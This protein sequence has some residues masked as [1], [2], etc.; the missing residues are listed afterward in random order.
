MN[1]PAVRKSD[2]RLELYIITIFVLGISV[3][4]TTNTSVQ[5]GNQHFIYLAKSFLEGKLYFS[6]VSSL[7]VEDMSL[8]DGKY[9][10]SLGFIPAILMMPFV[11]IFGNQVQHSVV[12]LPLVLGTVYLLY[13]IS[14]SFLKTK[15]LVLLL[16]FSYVFSTAYIM[17]AIAP[18]SWYFSH[19]VATFFLILSI[20]L[21]ILKNKPFLA[22]LFFSCAFLTRI[23]LLFSLPFFI[24]FPYFFL[25]EKSLSQIIKFIIPVSLGALIFFTYN[26]L[27]F[28]NFFETGY[29]YQ[30]L[31]PQL[32]ANRLEGMWSIKHFA[33]NLYLFFISSPIVEFYP[34]SFVTRRIETNQLGMSFLFTS[35]I[36]LYLSKADLKN[37]LNLISLS[38]VFLTCIFLFGSFGLG[39]RQYGYRF[40]LDFQPFLYIMLCGVFKD[41]EFGLTP[42]V[43]STVSFFVNLYFVYT[44]FSP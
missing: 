8:Y 3:I 4:L 39:C 5:F 27:R 33:S 16:P 38:A 31:F 14:K 41:K 44:H 29:R 12:S 19:V 35:P 13:K 42:Y 26:Y 18:F 25:K 23:S 20:Y 17:V 10:W 24:L 40:A 30:I 28:D 43:L 1:T 36:L 21:T 37:K 32:V 6:D 22:G 9:Y 11:A 7:G 34:G 15:S 2:R